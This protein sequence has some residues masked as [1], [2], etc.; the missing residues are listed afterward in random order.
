VGYTLKRAQTVL[1]HALELQLRPHGLSVPQYAC[2][3]LLAQQPGRSHAELARGAFVSRQ[4]VHQLVTGLRKAGLIP[5]RGDGRAQRVELTRE[6][7]R[8]LKAASST[9]MAV[10][11]TMLTGLD[12]AQQNAL[13][14]YLLSCI[15]S[16]GTGR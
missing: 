11:R 15:E 7:E 5:S 10:E 3:E 14:Q 2:L 12:E 6:G 8:R 4:A 13:Y 9:A 1:H 16:L